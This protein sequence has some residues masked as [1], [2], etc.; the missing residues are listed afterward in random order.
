MNTWMR[1]LAQVAFG[2]MLERMNSHIKRTIMPSW[3]KKIDKK[4]DTWLILKTQ[5]LVVSF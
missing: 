2:D 4:E 1:I 5:E 3:K